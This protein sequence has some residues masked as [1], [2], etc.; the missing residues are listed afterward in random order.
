M[1]NFNIANEKKSR[2][3][4]NTDAKN[5]VDDQ[6]AIVQAL[7]TESFDIRGIIAAHFGDQKSKQSMIDSYDEIIKL[8]DLMDMNKKNLVY[9]G[10]KKALS[11]NKEAIES[12]GQG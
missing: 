7:L 8:M 6:F 2:V 11:H 10:A 4:I 1:S 3:I 9:K 12:D 5:E